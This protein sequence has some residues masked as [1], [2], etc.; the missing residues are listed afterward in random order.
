MDLRRRLLLLDTTIREIDDNN[1]NDVSTKAISALALVVLLFFSLPTPA[2]YE[3]RISAEQRPNTILKISSTPYLYDLELRSDSATIHFSPPRYPGSETYLSLPNDFIGTAFS[4]VLTPKYVKDNLGVPK[5]EILDSH[6]QLNIIRQYS[7]LLINRESLTPKEILEL[8][9]LDFD[10]V[11]NNHLINL[12]YYTL[13][14]DFYRTAQEILVKIAQRN[15]NTN[16]DLF[17]VKALETY[18]Y[19]NTDRYQQS[20]EAGLSALSQIPHPVDD[21]LPDWQ[22]YVHTQGLIG[23]NQVILGKFSNNISSMENGFTKLNKAIEQARQAER[24]NLLAR[25]YNYQSAYF[26]LNNQYLNEQE[27]LNF[28]LNYA[29]SSNYSDVIPFITSNL[30]QSYISTGNIRKS[31]QILYGTLTNSNLNLSDREK[32]S[33]NYKLAQGYQL[34][35]ENEA[36]IRFYTIAA[37]FYKQSESSHAF[38]LT[39]KHLGKLFRLNKQ[40]QS[41]NDHLHL[42]LNYYEKTQ[43]Q[44]IY[45]IY[46]E[47][48]ETQIASGN[49]LGAE[50]YLRLA[51]TS[52]S[53]KSEP[54]L[55]LTEAKFNIYANRE[56]QAHRALE[57]IDNLMELDRLSIDQNLERLHLKT[58][59]ATRLR[60]IEET[61]VLFDQYYN[62]I[63]SVGK[64][65]ES[66][67]VTL[68]WNERLQ[69][70]AQL[71][72]S[73]LV[74]THTPIAGNDHTNEIFSVLEKSYNL[75]LSNQRTIKAI[76]PNNESWENLI[77]L[78]RE[79]VSE[80]NQEVK[81]T[82]VNEYNRIKDEYYALNLTLNSDKIGPN[83]P[84]DT[85]EITSN[86]EQETLII[87]YFSIGKNIYFIFGDRSKL[88]LSSP[89]KSSLYHHH[90]RSQDFSA[91]SKHAFPREHLLKGAYKKLVII[92][93]PE[94]EIFPIAAVNIGD[95]DGPYIPL[96]DQFF[97]SYTHSL[98]DYLS[99]TLQENEYYYDLTIFADPLFNL[100][101]NTPQTTISER[102]WL[103]TLAALPWTGHEAERIAGIY[104]THRTQLL[105]KNLATASNLLDDKTLNSEVLHIATHGYYDKTYPE[106]VGLATS[107]VDA[108]GIKVPNFVSLNT[109]LLHRVKSKL[110][111]ISGCETNLGKTSNTET[112]LSL[113]RELIAQGAGSTISTLWPVQDKATALLMERFYYHLKLNNGNSPRALASAQKDIYT[114]PRYRSPK[115]WAGFLIT[116][117]NRQYES[118]VLSISNKESEVNI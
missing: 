112:A 29:T 71:Y 79:V 50:E 103:E 107:V 12:L 25:L 27:A 89:F 7:Q 2:Q 37:S 99:L 49:L 26:G 91:L 48:T 57:A 77:R 6:P 21:K 4:L 104:S 62:T 73:L 65:L 72:L 95:I 87:R 63:H 47:L 17:R 64:E 85:F 117:A 115:N 33:L 40:Y 74:E 110:V 69:N 35:G 34:L 14:H 56:K 75:G 46:L 10:Q 38:A 9:N 101:E 70:I 52:T 15:S 86:L 80:A 105:T 3:I 66:S 19:L 42:A 114:I 45:K 24:P 111:I 44:Q 61:R 22:T 83:Q 16:T 102:S 5:F 96:I 109:L 13:E 78:E 30:A 88:Y 43:N 18:L 1:Q 55:W 81:L 58:L 53:L 98:N 92:G 100:I 11:A 41:A 82:Y 108:N 118:G 84:V 116:V 106:F 36:A 54:D 32:A 67:R 113:S 76:K 93:S 94:L 28:A 51:K 59:L 8:A 20:Y 23:L 90:I 31:Q 39:N 97:V 60:R 68:I